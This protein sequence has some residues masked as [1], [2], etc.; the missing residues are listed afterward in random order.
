MEAQIR[1]QKIKYYKE[2]VT[3]KQC[4]AYDYLFYATKIGEVWHKQENESI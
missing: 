2:N 3:K 1:Q 4:G